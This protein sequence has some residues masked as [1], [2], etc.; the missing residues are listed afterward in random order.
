[1]EKH[2]EVKDPPLRCEAMKYGVERRDI[3]FVAFTSA[4]VE[5]LYSCIYLQNVMRKVSENPT[6]RLNSE[7]QEIILQIVFLYLSLFGDDS[8]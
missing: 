5:D 3:K 7:V 1:M 2:L 6:W 8:I 4:S